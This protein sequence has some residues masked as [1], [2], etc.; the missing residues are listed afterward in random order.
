MPVIFNPNN[1]ETGRQR[2]IPEFEL[3]LRLVYIVSFKIAR[4]TQ[5]NHS[6]LKTTK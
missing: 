6:V 1:S 4:T 5:R 2:Q 3:R